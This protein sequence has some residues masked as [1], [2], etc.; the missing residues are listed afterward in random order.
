[1]GIFFLVCLVGEFKPKQ[2]EV[3]MAIGTCLDCGTMHDCSY[4]TD[5]C[6]VECFKAFSRY[7]MEEE[8]CDFL[9]ED[10]QSEEEIEREGWK[11]LAEG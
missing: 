2:E 5:F 9:A 3:I 1:M 11:K 6:N 4:S 10:E 7:L 8:L